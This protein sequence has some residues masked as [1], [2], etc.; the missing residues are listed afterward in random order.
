MG[1]FC[2]DRQRNCAIMRL[3]ILKF[4][5]PFSVGEGLDPPFAKRSYHKQ[6]GQTAFA[7]GRV[8]TLPYNLV[9]C[10]VAK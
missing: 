8:K 6:K 10:F 9:A 3:D 2:F 1:P 7:Q 4:I 5:T